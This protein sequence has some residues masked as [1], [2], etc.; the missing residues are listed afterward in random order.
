[1]EGNTPAR[2]GSRLC[3]TPADKW[4]RGPARSRQQVFPAGASGEP[5]DLSRPAPEGVSTHATEGF[6]ML[7]VRPA[8]RPLHM[9][10]I[11][12]PLPLGLRHT[13]HRRRTI[14]QHRLPRS[15]RLPHAGQRLA[16]IVRAPRAEPA[17]APPL[18][19]LV[20]AVWY[21]YRLI[22]QRTSRAACGKPARPS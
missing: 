5:F 3:V 13:A 18:L 2:K 17:A 1:M 8:G 16:E 12:R 22:V 21:G 19:P 9:R 4:H 20:W 10:Q 15:L 14:L 6:S 11:L 7:C